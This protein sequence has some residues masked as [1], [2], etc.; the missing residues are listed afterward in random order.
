[1]LPPVLD[2]LMYAIGD[3]GQQ[4]PYLLPTQPHLEQGENA[5]VI[6]ETL[7]RGSRFLAADLPSPRSVVGVITASHRPPWTARPMTRDAR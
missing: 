3:V 1:V 2:E 4:M 6:F 5:Q 7:N